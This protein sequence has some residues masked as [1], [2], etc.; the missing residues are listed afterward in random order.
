MSTADLHGDWN[1]N[2]RGVKLENLILSAFELNICA[3]RIETSA[4][5]EGDKSTFSNFMAQQKTPPCPRQFLRSAS[6]LKFF[7]S[8]M[9]TFQ[10][11]ILL[12]LGGDWY[13][14]WNPRN[15]IQLATKS[16]LIRFAQSTLHFLLK[17]QICNTNSREKYSVLHWN[18]PGMENTLKDNRCQRGC[19]LE[20]ANKGILC[21][22]S[23]VTLC[24]GNWKT[25]SE[26]REIV[27]G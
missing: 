15:Q 17:N 3:Q 25:N 5:R 1:F 21:L 22:S 12:L 6:T 7:L 26:R 9:F 18:G 13:T 23:K 10:D 4:M 20:H 24:G 19:N 14:R 8:A 2:L 11:L 16:G 27:Y